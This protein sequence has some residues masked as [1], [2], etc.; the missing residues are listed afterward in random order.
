MRE[1]HGWQ[2]PFSYSHPDEEL[3]TFQNCAGVSDLSYLTKFD[4][5]R[6]VGGHALPGHYWQISRTH[7]LLT[8]D[9]PFDTRSVGISATD[10][11][12][13]YAALM[14]AGPHSRSV[15]N[16]VTSLNISES[17]F[18]RAAIRG[19]SL[20][21][22]HALVARQDLGRLTS[23]LLFL[24]RDTAEHTWKVLLQAGSE[25]GVTA[26]GFGAFDQTT[27]ER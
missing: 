12:S 22:T 16:K 15:L 27:G 3:S 8:S 19:C 13:C 20:A 2:L 10:V 21:H 11:T 23:F 25:F 7:G 1:H 18:P 24:A 4:I 14:I 9:D 5:K 6:G 17:A 26:C